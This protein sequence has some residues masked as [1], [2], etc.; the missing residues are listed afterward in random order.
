VATELFGTLPLDL[1]SLLEF[2]E[3]I[4]CDLAKAAARWKFEQIDS[5]SDDLSIS[6]QTSEIWVYKLKQACPIPFI[7]PPS[8]V[9]L[10][11]LRLWQRG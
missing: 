2:F 9:V 5:K 4:R 3:L 10:V 7:Y 1:L 6:I 11:S 8:S